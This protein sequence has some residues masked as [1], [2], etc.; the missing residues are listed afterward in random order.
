MSQAVAAPST[1]DPFLTGGKSANAADIPTGNIGQ[2]SPSRRTV[3]ASLALASVASV[4]IP[5]EA[6]AVSRSEWDRAHNEYRRL[7]MLMDAYYDLGPMDW[8]NEGFLLHQRLKDTDPIGY[9]AAVHELRKQED[10]SERYY[11][12]VRAAAEKLVRLPAP[13]LDAVAIKM[14]LHKSDLEG[15]EHHELAWLCIEADLKRLGQ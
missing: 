12:P 14:S 1:G 13:D 4:M 7:R 5:T 15:T 9:E 6:G 3:L 10:Q 11:M 8:A 2:N